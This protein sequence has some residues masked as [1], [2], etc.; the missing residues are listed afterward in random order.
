MKSMKLKEE[1][2]GK[3]DELA[4]LFGEALEKLQEGKELS[5]KDGALRPL[6]KRLL[7]VSLDAELDQ[8][9]SQSKT[10][11]RNGRGRKTVKTSHGTVEIETVRDRDGSFEPQIIGKRQTTLGASVDNKIL[12]LYGMG[13]SYRD[14][15][16]HVDEMYGLSLS[17]A[18][19]TAITDQ[20]WPEVQSWRERPLDSKYACVWLDAMHYKVRE[21]G[22]VEKRAVYMALAR[23]L[24]GNKELLGFYVSKS[25]SA[26]F[27]MQV[28]N[29]LQQRGVEDILICCIDNLK[30]FVEAIESVFPRT[31]VQLCIVHQ[32]R[33]SMRYVPW[34]DQREV[35]RDLK[36]VYRSV[37]EE[38][39]L[40]KL[41][42]FEDKWSSKYKPMVDSWKR[43]W[44]E[45]A[46]MFKYPAAIRKMIYTTNMI[47]G[48]H[49]Q[50]RKVTKT[51]GAFS[52][53]RA[54]I[55]LLYLA[56]DRIAK[57]WQRAPRDWKQILNA[58]VIFY[59]DRIKE[60]VEND[61]TV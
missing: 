57:D 52:N 8:H 19:L 21:E 53:D 20:I 32:V 47:E 29:D 31:D 60:D 48:F 26:K 5:G 3:Q 43:N 36:E 49:R 44:P 10:N 37:N 54:L 42:K 17:P 16:E 27:W 58:L 38:Q 59:E 45:L 2:S 61:D 23:K 56:Q 11:R 46:T 7:E 50:I 18:T 4:N 51:K 14:I 12:S 15:R 41:A 55:K 1:T 25:E 6:I 24:N 34:S 39:G 9:V 30:G 35:V 33:N 40:E 22:V 13:M 28:L